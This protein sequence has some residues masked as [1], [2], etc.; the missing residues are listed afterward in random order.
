MFRI[1]DLGAHDGFVSLWL[2]RQLRE[3]GIEDIVIHGIELHP[4]GVKVANERAEREGFTADYKQGL[5]EDAPQLFHTGV[6]DAVIAFE[7]IEHVPD[8]PLFLS[9][10]EDMC[11]SGG[12]VY[13]STPDGCFGEG[14]NPHHLRVYRSIDLFNLC[15]QRGHIENLHVG[16][17]GVV[18]LR[19]TPTWPVP[20]KAAIYTGGGWETWHPRDITERG[21]GGSE[22]AAVR[23]AEALSD[24]DFSVTIY[25]E[26]EEGMYRQIEL[27][28]HSVFDPMEQRDLM[29]IS[30]SPQIFDR[31]HRAKKAH[32]WMHDTDYGPGALSPERLDK[33]DKVLV[34]SKWHAD[35]VALM[36][37][38]ECNA[39]IQ[40][41]GNGINPDFFPPDLIPSDRPRR[42][43]Y[44]SSPDRGLD[45]M[46]TLWPK[47]RE[48]VPDAEL[49]YCY[50]DVYNKVADVDPKIAAFRGRC[51]SL[52]D[53]PGVV[54]LGSLPQDKLAAAMAMCRVWLAPSYNTVHNV[55]FNE[56]F[57][58]GA[59]ESAAAGC[60]RIMSNWGALPERAYESGDYTLISP[61][62]TT[63][64][65]EDE[66][67]DAIVHHLTDE[68]KVYHSCPR[69]RE[70]TW[71]KVAS[72]IVASSAVLA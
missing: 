50:A 18:V 6:Y 4:H 47:V 60:H 31:K 40:V 8:V 49:V 25:G 53:Q 48:R 57:C 62:P 67:V 66:W 24:L 39:K 30:R 65:G 14:Q 43:I 1:L 16:K 71:T 5:A 69:A 28:H 35:H 56:T 36:Y 59:V 3:R 58:I 26:V 7:V 19:Y 45:L 63:A 20:M 29:I 72:D 10:C 41:I 22:T 27:R 11:K 52:A 23:L 17:D 64:G 38:A 55:P 34:L 12:Q 2:A 9:V 61:D 42:A 21:L 15:R 51:R 54:N 68:T 70:V 13:L 37:G 44:S 33:I 32:L 46:L